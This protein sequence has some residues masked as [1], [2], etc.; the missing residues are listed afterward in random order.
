MKTKEGAL[1]LCL[2]AASWLSYM[3]QIHIGILTYRVMLYFEHVKEEEES[4]K[5]KCKFLTCMTPNLKN[6]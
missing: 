5:C 3:Y 4:I 6:S 1:G 2:D